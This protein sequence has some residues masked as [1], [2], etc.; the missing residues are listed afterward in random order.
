ME[1]AQP[2]ASFFIL[3]PSFLHPFLGHSVAIFCL[4]PSVLFFL[5][6]LR[7]DLM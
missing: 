6:R 5:F 7:Q 3:P 1:T 4:P 2:P